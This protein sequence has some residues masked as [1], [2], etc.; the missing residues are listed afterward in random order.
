MERPFV[1]LKDDVCENVG[2]RFVRASKAA[3]RPAFPQTPVPLIQSAD[4]P[5]HNDDE[6][7]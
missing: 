3:P 1:N 7:L 6:S 4:R 2:A 5:S